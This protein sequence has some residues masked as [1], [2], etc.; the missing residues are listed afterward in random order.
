MA[1]LP[2]ATIYTD[3]GCRPNPGPGGWGAVILR[4]GRQPLE[5]SGGDPATT[6]NRMELTAALEALRAL[7][8]PHEVELVTDSQYLRRGIGEWLP[9]W[10]ARGWR[11]R[12]GGEVANRDLWEALE[13]ELGR[14]RV[15][16]RWVRGHSGDRWNERADR[17]AR[18]AIPA[19]GGEAPEADA[20]A[21]HL[22]LGIAAS[23][24]HRRGAW[25]AI[26]AWRDRQRT[27]AGAV[28][29]PAPNRLHLLAAVRGLEALRRRSRVHL[30]TVS[31]W[32]AQGASRWIHGWRRR[33]WRRRDGQPVAHADLWRRL[34]AL[35]DRHDVRWHVRGGDD[36]PPE[37]EMA[38]EAAREALGRVSS[39]R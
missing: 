23:A 21:V 25:G 33:G 18:A 13:A 8:T 26:L 16:W 9:A 37:I 3:G 27:L 32:L 1:G 6:N 36:L 29:D 11:T 34:E 12:S 24:R 17:L 20:D 15:R 22:F 28:D 19:A 30:Y 35:A 14:H 2:R 39:R 38:R 7:E 31:D 4:E 10:R 5:L